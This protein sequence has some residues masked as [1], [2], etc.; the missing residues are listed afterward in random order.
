MSDTT[1][2]S[3]GLLQILVH[4]YNTLKRSLKSQVVIQSHP[5]HNF[6]KSPPFDMKVESFERLYKNRKQFD[7][8]KAPNYM[9]KL[10]NLLPTLSKVLGRTG[11]ILLR[12]SGIVNYYKHIYLLIKHLP[13]TSSSFFTYWPRAYTKYSYECADTLLM[14]PFWKLALTG[15]PGSI[16]ACLLYFKYGNPKVTGSNPAGNNLELYT[17]L[18]RTYWYTP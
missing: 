9:Q 3:M 2:Y 16:C 12:T 18:V 5:A 15:G 14:M 11:T 13:V 7:T 4:A 10:M 8:K 6:L 17:Y 1:S